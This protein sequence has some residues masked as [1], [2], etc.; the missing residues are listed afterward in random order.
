MLHLGLY[1]TAAATCF[2]MRKPNR[3]AIIYAT[4]KMRRDPMPG[5]L[6]GYPNAAQHHA[7]AIKS[8]K[9]TVAP[10]PVAKFI[11]PAAMI[12]TTIS[13][14]K[15]GVVTQRITRATVSLEPSWLSSTVGVRSAA[16]SKHQ[17]QGQ[18]VRQQGDRP[19]RPSRSRCI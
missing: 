14:V 6:D 7:V 17:S 5:I 11:G 3:L 16:G 8:S 9:F 2:T 15:H 12:R 18:R 13:A 4:R 19:Q 10:A 1:S